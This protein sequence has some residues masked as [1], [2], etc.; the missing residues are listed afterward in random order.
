MSLIFRTPLTLNRL[1]SVVN[2]KV[3]AGGNG[4]DSRE[5]LV[6]IA[7][8]NA[9][10]GIPFVP[11]YE[12]SHSPYGAHKPVRGPVSGRRASKP[13]ADFSSEADEDD[14]SA[15]TNDEATGQRG[16]RESAGAVA[17]AAQRGDDMLQVI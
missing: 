4:V 14:R 10:H 2:D 17:A 7:G 12:T 11:S 1:F 16:G 15:S 6:E 13:A 3:L 8:E 9:S 5:T